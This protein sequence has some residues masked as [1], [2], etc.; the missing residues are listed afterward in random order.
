[1]EMIRKS[2]NPAMGYRYYNSTKE[3]IVELGN[4]YEI[5]EGN[6]AERLKLMQKFWEEVRHNGTKHIY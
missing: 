1:M 5:I 3:E 4:F 6:P 2:G